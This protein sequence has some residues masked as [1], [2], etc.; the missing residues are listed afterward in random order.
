MRYK[1]LFLD[2]KFH[3]KILSATE[4]KKKCVGGGGVVSPSPS[5]K[6]RVKLETDLFM[7]NF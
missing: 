1:I 3:L 2:W 5:M 6:N 4:A 7:E